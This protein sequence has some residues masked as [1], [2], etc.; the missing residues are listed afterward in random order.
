MFALLCGLMWLSSPA[1]ALATKLQEPG[2]PEG[3]AVYV[4]NYPDL[5]TW[6]S[7]TALGVIV[8]LLGLIAAQL[9]SI[10][11]T[12]DRQGSFAGSSSSPAKTEG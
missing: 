10:K 6:A 1:I 3:D 9:A 4:L 5:P 8:V 7:V 12:L 11:A 2:K